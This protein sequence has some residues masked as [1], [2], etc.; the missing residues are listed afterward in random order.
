MIC[1]GLALARPNNS[2]DNYMHV[3]FEYT[4]IIIMHLALILLNLSLR[5]VVICA[6]QRFNY[7]TCVYKKLKKL[8]ML[9]CKLCA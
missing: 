9:K 8:A 2:D 5:R 4:L 6:C 7:M 3:E 1:V